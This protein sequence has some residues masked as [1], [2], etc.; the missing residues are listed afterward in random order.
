LGRLS[1]Y[2]KSVFLSALSSYEELA[3]RRFRQYKWERRKAEFDQAAAAVVIRLFE[4]VVPVLQQTGLVRK[5]P[6]E[7]VTVE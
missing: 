6:V 4:T 3:A 5:R 2:I 7:N 1:L